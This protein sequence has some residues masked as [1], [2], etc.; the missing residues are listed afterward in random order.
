MKIEHSVFALWVFFSS[1]SE[2]D[3]GHPGWF[4]HT[5]PQKSGTSVVAETIVCQIPIYFS[6]KS[7]ENRALPRGLKQSLLFL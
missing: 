4:P 7:V 5:E 3:L 6:T 1:F 2:A